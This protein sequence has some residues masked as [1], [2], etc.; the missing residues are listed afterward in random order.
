MFL[1]FKDV[2][3]SWNGFYIVIYLPGFVPCASRFNK[4]IL[5]FIAHFCFQVNFPNL[6]VNHNFTSVFYTT[7]FRK[8]LLFLAHRNTGAA[9]AF[10][11][12]TFQKSIKCFYFIYLLVDKC[13]QFFL[14]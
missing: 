8:K 14:C 4:N 3:Q 6:I 9:L 13:G 11:A 12:F 2:I 10:Y 1:A 7:K 5:P